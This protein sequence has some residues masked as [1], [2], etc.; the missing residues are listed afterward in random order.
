MTK[1]LSAT[2][3]ILSHNLAHGKL[4]PGA[5]I[6]LRAD[7]LQAQDGTGTMVFLHLQR[8]G[9]VRLRGKLAVCYVDHNTLGQGGPENADDH[10]FLET[11]CARYGLVYSRPG[12]GIG[13]QVHLER[14][15][16]PGQV[17]LGADS[18]VVTMGGAGMLAI[19]TGGM[20][21]AVA[22][23]G[24]PHYMICPS[25]VRVVL[26]G[27]LRPWCSAKDAVLQLLA[28]ASG[29][30]WTNT[31]FEYCGDGVKTLSV[32]QRATMANMGAEL[33]LTASLF[34]SDEVT[35]AWLVAQGRGRDYRRL[36]VPLH[37]DVADELLLDLSEVEPMVAL[38]PSPLKSVPLAQVQGTVVQQVAVGS[39]TNGSFEDIA[40]VAAMLKGKRV[41][42][43]L[44]L[45]VTPASRQVMQ[46]LW[47]R[48]HLQ[49]LID[50]GARIAE[51]ACGF[52]IGQGFAPASG[53]VSVRTVN[54]NYEGR[55]GTKDAQVYLVSPATAA[56]TALK[57]VLTDPRTLRRQPPRISL[58]KKFP[59][60]DRLIARHEHAGRKKIEIVRGPNIVDPPPPEPL[61]DF[62]K[63][64]VTLKV[65]DNIT[66]D[67]ILPAGPYLKFRSNV[68]EY[69]WHT[70]KNID[71]RFVHRAKEVQK[72]GLANFI[73]AGLD[74]GAGSSR[75]H[76]AMCP[77]HLGVR[78]ILAKGYARLH[79]ANLIHH[80]IVP[81]TFIDPRD[82]DRIRQEDELE[83][84]WLVAELRRSSLVTVRSPNRGYELRLK[85]SLSR[86]QVDILL[87][88]SLL[89]YV[90]KH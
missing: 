23:A 45:V 57:G 65:G 29:R 2:Y 35:R 40:Q 24:V 15:A 7:Q 6:G 76:A 80:G 43:G 60:D 50:A 89:D 75:E 51:P 37:A 20:E 46:A 52:C 88:G 16:V 19:A 14:F 12:N 85:H 17:L 30:S 39:C 38:P 47:Q 3:S 9:R 84:P 31:V 28:M 77:R 61:P 86:R 79:M 59:A 10:R 55:C 83:V 8:L 21:L 72:R 18:H 49:A 69:A 87:S 11:A 78:V 67:H 81:L 90:M 32:Q 26:K 62:I 5:E 54:R 73:V 33:G 44:E 27:K 71:R 74:Y 68:Q 63:G 36:E 13:H 48:G 82:Y 22:M 42:E 1:R 34:P 53:T 58:P 64:V 56:A 41:A 70:F 66:T 4:K 25:V